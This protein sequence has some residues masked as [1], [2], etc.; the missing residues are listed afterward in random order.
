MSRNIPTKIEQAAQSDQVDY[1]ELLTIYLDETT[2]Y[3]VAND[4]QNL[5]VNGITY[6]AAMIT[7]DNIE[8]TTDGSV[9]NLSI[10]LANQ[11]SR[12]SAYFALNANKFWN[13]RCKL[14]QVYLDYLDEPFLIYPGKL[15]NP[16]MTIEKFTASVVWELGDFESQSPNMTYDVMCQYKAFKDERCR[17]SGTTF[18]TCDRTLQSC[19]ERGNVTRFGG[20]PSI[21]RQMVVRN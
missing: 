10:E 19:I 13:R 8:S 9:Q 3:F 15:K 20:H 17:Y 5:I 7:R 2:L 6:E 1:R 12:W 16:H 4:T 18:D 21:T 11:D 14:E